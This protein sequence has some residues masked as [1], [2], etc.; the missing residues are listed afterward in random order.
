MDQITE[1]SSILVNEDRV[2]WGSQEGDPEI[3][4][5]SPDSLALSLHSLRLTQHCFHGNYHKVYAPGTFRWSID[6]SR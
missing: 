3:H 5:F 1:A 4:T 2:L 6:W